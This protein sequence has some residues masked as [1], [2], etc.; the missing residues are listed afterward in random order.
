[1]STRTNGA[2]ASSMLPSDEWLLVPLHWH[3]HA[4]PPK[5]DGAPE[6][7]LH[8]PSAV[9]TW[10]AEHSTANLWHQ[11]FLTASRGDS[12]RHN[13]L[14]VKAVLNEKCTHGCVA[15]YLASGHRR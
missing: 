14:V 12:I 1:M 13:Q 7:A 15:N 9:A 4:Q 8:H 2:A 5:P 3:A 10:L 6:A 11:H